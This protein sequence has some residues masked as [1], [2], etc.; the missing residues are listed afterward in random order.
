MHDIAIAKYLN[1]SKRITRLMCPSSPVSTCVILI[2]GVAPRFAGSRS[3]A[4]SPSFTP[5]VLAI[6]MLYN[7][8]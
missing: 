8:T 1:P 7:L 2:N 3:K 4:M 6:Y 5:I